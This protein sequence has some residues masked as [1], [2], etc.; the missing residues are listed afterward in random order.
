MGIIERNVAVD[1]ENTSFDSEAEVL[2][3][4]IVN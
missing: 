1:G 3:K 4:L 2:G